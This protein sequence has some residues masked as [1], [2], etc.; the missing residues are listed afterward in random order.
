M[1]NNLD[2]LDSELAAEMKMYIGDSATEDSSNDLNM[3]HVTLGAVQCPQT[4]LKVEELHNNIPL[5]QRFRIKLNVFFSV[6]DIA[7]AD[8][9]KIKLMPTDT[10]SLCSITAFL[11]GLEHSNGSILDHR[12]SLSES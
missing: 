1:R 8:G 12:T 3:F 11:N 4:L 5:F 2:A 6:Y 10:V 7:Q 9:K